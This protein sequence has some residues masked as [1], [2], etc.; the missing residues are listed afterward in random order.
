MRYVGDAREKADIEQLICAQLV[1]LAEEEELQKKQSARM[2]TLV[3][4]KGAERIADFLIG[5]GL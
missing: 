5:K 4:G 1:K 2:E 3:D